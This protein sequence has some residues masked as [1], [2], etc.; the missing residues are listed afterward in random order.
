MSRPTGLRRERVDSSA[1]QDLLTG[2]IVSTPFCAEIIP[3]IQ[4]DDV[5]SDYARRIV[6]WCTEYY[7]RYSEA[8]QRHIESLYEAEKKN[9]RPE[10]GELIATLLSNLSER[11]E[12]ASEYNVPYMVDR[13]R[14]YIDERRARIRIANATVLLDRGKVAEALVELD[15]GAST[16]RLKGAPFKPLAEGVATKLLAR[17]EHDPLFSYPG[18]LGE[19]IGTLQRK[20]FVVFMGPAKRGKT[21]WLLYTALCG[22]RAKKKV[23]YASLEMDPE[24]DCARLYQMLTRT[25][26]QAGKVVIP[27][28]DCKHNQTGTCDRPIRTNRIPL[29]ETADAPLPPFRPEMNYRRCDECRREDPT[30]YAQATWWEQREYEGFDPGKVERVN[31]QFRVHYGDNLYMNQYPKFDTTLDDI[32]ADLDWLE[33]HEG[34]VADIVII[35]YMDILKHMERGYD[36]RGQVNATWKT[37]SRKAGE[38]KQLIVSATQGNRSTFKTKNIDHEGVGEDIRK[39]AHVNVLMT[40]NQDPREKSEGK[41]RV[42]LLAHRHRDFND[43]IQSLVLYDR[44]IGSVYIDSELVY[45]ADDS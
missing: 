19:M 20:W 34:W 42:G 41:L 2:L 4:Y 44:R 37:A 31:K 13:A 10:E 16:K 14:S 5:Q 1:E 12:H 38:R 11:Y 43:Y 30:A 22:L 32:Y 7:D 29:L 3:E 6:S 35:D 25:A 21:F 8:P 39:L 45:V 23:Y 17:K 15:R 18:K 33:Q 40:L 36:E 9:I 27:M 24:E 28:F 26:A